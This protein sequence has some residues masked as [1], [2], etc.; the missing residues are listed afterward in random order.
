MRDAGTITKEEILTAFGEQCDE[1]FAPAMTEEQFIKSIIYKGTEEDAAVFE[2]QCA[3][4]VEVGLW[5][6]EEVK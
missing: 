3:Y 4:R 1:G 2:I 5:E 6:E